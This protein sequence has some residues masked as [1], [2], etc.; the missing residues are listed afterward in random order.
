MW[1][2]GIWIIKAPFLFYVSSFSLVF[3]V[4]ETFAE[5]TWISNVH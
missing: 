5:A 1:A 4:F 2:N 3:E